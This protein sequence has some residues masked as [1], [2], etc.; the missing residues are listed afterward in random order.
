MK[1][2][3]ELF[4]EERVFWETLFLAV[5]AVL[6]A[7]H[8]LETSLLFQVVSEKVPKY[9]S[10]SLWLR[11]FAAVAVMAKAVREER[12]SLKEL[13]LAVF[14]LVSFWRCL[15]V[16]GYEELMDLAIVVFGARR[17]PLK[18][19]LTV[20]VAVTGG[21]IVT[22]VVASGLGYVEDWLFQN[23]SGVIKHSFGFYYPN[24][25]GAHV[26]FF[27][28]GLCC[29]RREKISVAEILLI[30][31]CAVLLEK[32]CYSRTN[33]FCL[34]LL[35]AGMSVWKILT[36]I[37]H[38]YEKQA[39]KW[40]GLVLALVPLVCCAVMLVLTLAMKH[41]PDNELLCHINSFFSERL[42]FGAQGF[43][44]YGVTLFGQKIEMVGM[45]Q[46]TDWANYNFLDCSYIMLLIRCGLAPFL[47]VGLLMGRINV[48][49]F[50]NRDMILLAAM[51]LCGIQ[52]MMEHHLYDIGY[53]PLLLAAFAG[54]PDPRCG[55]GKESADRTLCTE[56]RV[57]AG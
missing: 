27:F 12:F 55:G 52:C 26:F 43:T 42:H 45:A 36:R 13:L 48:R 9:Y 40:M 47:A 33:F 25:F 18:K 28:L 32:F 50:K 21:L 49:A 6:L 1:R 53:N 56:E 39:V 23:S 34:L 22:V 7:K 46:Q 31:V 14:V 24:E 19:I 11:L 5:Y 51:A 29:L 17:V 4:R 44:N 3:R 10:Y 41:Y 54:L 57:K 20:Y 37:P 30:V 8:V 2:C 38:V 15:Q 16:A 35:A